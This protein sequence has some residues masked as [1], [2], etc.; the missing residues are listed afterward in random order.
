MRTR[1]TFVSCAA[2]I[3]FAGVGQAQNLVSNPLFA[4][5]GNDGQF[6]DSWT[7]VGSAAFASFAGSLG[8]GAATD[9][10]PDALTFDGAA[11][12]PAN[13]L[14]NIGNVSQGDIAVT[15]GETYEFSLQFQS[16]G[17][18]VADVT[19]AIEFR[20]SEDNQ[21]ALIE[22]TVDSGRIASSS[23]ARVRAQAPG[24]ATTAMVSVSYADA[25][26]DPGA[27]AEITEALLAMVDAA[28]LLSNP[29]FEDKIGLTALAAGEGIFFQSGTG[30]DD[31]PSF[32]TGFMDFFSF[33]PGN[34][35]ITFFGDRL[36]RAGEVFQRGIPAVPGEE[37]QFRVATNFEST[38]QFE[39][40]ISDFAD[41]F[42][43]LDFYG[44]DDT[45]LIQSVGYELTGEG[46][47]GGAY[48]NT[49][50]VVAI[51]PEGAA[52]V[53]P[54]LAFD[55]DPLAPVG[56]GGGQGA[57]FDAA[58]LNV[59]TATTNRLVNPGML[60]L[61]SPVDFFADHWNIFNGT[62]N[63]GNDPVNFFPFQTPN[64][65]FFDA[66]DPNNADG[67]VFQ[68][69]IPTLAGETYTLYAHISTEGGVVQGEGAVSLFV[70]LEFYDESDG[71]I[72]TGN[73]ATDVPPLAVTKLPVQTINSIGYQRFEVTVTAP[74]GA[75]FMRPVIG[76]EGGPIPNNPN[77]GEAILIDDVVLQLDSTD[78]GFNPGFEDLFEDG[79]FGDGWQTFGAANFDNFFPNGNPGHVI[80]FG[81]IASNEGGIFLQDIG[82]E[83]GK[84]YFIRADFQAEENYD[85]L[86]QLSIE[87]RA[88]ESSD[89]IEALLF[90]ITEQPGEGY[91]RV[92]GSAVAPAGAG[93]VRPLA[94]F[95]AASGA[96]DSLESATIDNFFVFDPVDFDE[97]GDVDASD[98]NA[99][100]DPQSPDERLDLVAPSGQ[101]F[102]DIAAF[103]N[104]I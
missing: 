15:P 17:G 91:K 43:S 8:S 52:F 75:V 18:F 28:N 90:E 2:L 88:D 89:P 7:A 78:I 48:F 93:V 49:V 33:E 73:L 51:A 87:F 1:H 19:I 57:T 71:R 60:D 68:Q 4:D 79:S 5:T 76:W 67:G 104:A 99:F 16:S 100:I 101:D 46:S 63:F 45:T 97:D 27:R 58:V 38:Y 66:A 56:P 20:D 11:V 82:A 84:T 21:L 53:R 86:T 6:G 54:R 92:Y 59:N 77:E 81:D 37:Y 55:V 95:E 36:D 61:A 44:P 30:W 74:A 50:G 22:E 3:A 72:G 29:T 80:F 85:A 39:D 25:T 65:A 83:P 26:G 12:F 24:D 31:D 47:I 32:D 23:R 34:G 64:H 41:T 103:Q 62:F 96:A 13:S 69:G 10:S 70:S 9:T 102:F 98:V 42:F 40:S 94:R 14:P 35:H